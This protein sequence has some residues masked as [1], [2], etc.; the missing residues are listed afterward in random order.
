MTTETRTLI[1]MKD[2]SGIEFKCPRC[3]A[4]VLYPF[5]EP[6]ARLVDKCP[7][8]FESWFA[9]GAHLPSTP[10]PVAEEIR[11]LFMALQ[12]TVKRKDIKARIRLHVTLDETKADPAS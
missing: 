9:G 7:N 6:I 4:C 12:D 8:C 5:G 11:Q 3:G 1:E 10:E 2:I